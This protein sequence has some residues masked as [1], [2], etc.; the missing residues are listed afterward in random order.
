MIIA[1]SLCLFVCPVLWPT[2]QT[3]DII[4]SLGFNGENCYLANVNTLA[5]KA[6]IRT[7]ANVTP[8]NR[9]ISCSYVAVSI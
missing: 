4:I 2:P 6:K 3:N 8:A 9:H 7:C 5:H 1:L